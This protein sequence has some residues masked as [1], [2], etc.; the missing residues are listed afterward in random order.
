MTKVKIQ[1][2]DCERIVEVDKDW[3]STST[4][5]KC[6]GYFSELDSNNKKIDEDSE[7]TYSCDCCGEEYIEKDGIPFYEDEDSKEN[8]DIT[9]FICKDC[10]KRTVKDKMLNQPIIKEKIVEKIVEKPIYI[11]VDSE[12]KPIQQQTNNIIFNSVL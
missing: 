11:K 8:N 3:D 5:M 9:I 12:G 7:D 1:C 4:C 6:G 2:D 10:Y